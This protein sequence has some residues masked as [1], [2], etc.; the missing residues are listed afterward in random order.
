MTTAL[1]QEQSGERNDSGATDSITLSSSGCCGASIIGNPICMIVGS[2][3]VYVALE[4][5]K[6]KL[7]TQTEDTH[8]SEFTRPQNDMPV[9]NT[10]SQTH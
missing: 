3:P 9:T 10:H 6:N 8:S 5:N 4:L 7:L 2:L 1:P